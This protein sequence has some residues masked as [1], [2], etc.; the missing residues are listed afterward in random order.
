MRYL[1]WEAFARSTCTY[2]RVNLG[3]YRDWLGQDNLRTT[4]GLVAARPPCFI[5]LGW[6]LPALGTAL[7]AWPHYTLSFLRSWVLLKWVLL[8]NHIELGLNIHCFAHRQ[9]LELWSQPG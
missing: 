3:P 7:E 8:L 4:L 6:W 1:R 5:P 9:L 2:A